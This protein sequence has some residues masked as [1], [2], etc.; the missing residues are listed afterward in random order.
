MLMDK[1]DFKDYVNTFNHKDSQDP[2]AVVGDIEE[3]D[4]K[5]IAWMHKIQKVWALLIVAMDL[6]DHA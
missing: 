1:Q 3:I 2:Y 6:F 5:Y 4:T